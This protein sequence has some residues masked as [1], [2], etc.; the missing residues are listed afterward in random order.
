[1]KLHPVCRRCLSAAFFLSITFLLTN[2]AGAQSRPGIITGTV[3]GPDTARLP[4]AVITARRAGSPSAL[5]VVSAGSGIYRLPDLEPGTYELK[6]ELEGFEPIF[7]T[8]FDLEAAET[9]VV[10]F[11]MK[12]ATIR[13]IITVVG[14]APRDSMEASQARE[15]S[16]RDVGEAL[17]QEPGVWKVRKGGIA[18]DVLV[19]GFQGK[20]LNVLIDGQRIYGACPN[21]MDPT[22]F[23][24]DFAEVERVEIGKG[25]FDVKNQGSLGGVVNIVTRQP[26]PGLHAVGSLS[27]GSYGFVNPAATISF[28]RPAA[29]ILAGYSYRLSQPY[30]DGSGKRFTQYTNYRSG[31]LD[32]DA[33]KIGTVWA[34]L[35]ARPF[36]KHLAQISYARQGAD[37]VLYPYLQMDALYDD[38]DRINAGYQIEDLSTFVHSLRVH[39]YYTKVNHWMT[40][41]YRT[42]SV[43]VARAYSMG[44][45]AATKALGGRLETNLEQVTVGVEAFRREWDGTTQMAGSGYAPQFSIPNVKTDSVGVYSE[46][47]RSISDR[48]KVSLGGRVD[49]ARSAADPSKA[50]T[51]LYYAYNSTRSTEARNTFPSGNLRVGYRLQDGTEFYLGVGHT[52][53]V[54]DPRER[55]FALRRMGT[56]WVGNPSLKP[57]RNTGVDSSFSVHRQKLA[58]EAALYLNQ[59]GDFVAVR[60]Q[61][62]ANLVSGV[63]NS[64]ARSYQNVDAKIYGGDFQISYLLTSRLFLSSDFSYVRGTQEIVPERG[65]VSP[66]L[67]EMP[68]MRSRTSMRYDTGRFSAEIEGIFAGAQRRVDTSL[69]EQATAGYGIANLRAG[70][71]LKRFALR[72]ALNNVLGRNYFEHL[73]YQRDPFRSG[74]RVFEPGRNL[75]A[76]LSYRF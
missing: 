42:S 50:N 74:V 14:A 8:S 44:T 73:S 11:D 63:M 60:P 45:L 62:K 52:V 3:T 38:A 31:F 4:G 15:S 1:M 57:S 13:E 18:N 26:E 39:A 67:A 72:L 27:T 2:S 59:I 35:S 22:A 20:D 5:K 16:A 10:N 12:I 53:R 37:H 25:P 34:K 48:L 33:F 21:H 56:D 23:H 54:P 49:T 66:N 70:M 68:P 69:L 24:A 65:I 51:N 17:A 28:G 43:G 58:L 61:A 41:E 64:N 36:S 46:Y 71:N 30:T 76:N 6:A 19:R 32:S 9:R 29:S 7:V 75:Y 40:D 55:Y 47:A